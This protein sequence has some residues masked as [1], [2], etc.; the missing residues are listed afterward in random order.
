M[1]S[2]SS[3]IDTDTEPVFKIWVSMTYTSPSLD[4]TYFSFVHRRDM[5]GNGIAQVLRDAKSHADSWRYADIEQI[6]YYAH[7]TRFR[8][9]CVL[10]RP[11]VV[12]TIRGMPDEAITAF[13]NSYR[14]NPNHGP[15][16]AN[17]AVLLENFESW[18]ELRDSPQRQL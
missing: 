18:R 15:T 17:L 14:I 6:V 2:I 9:R 3:S 4:N 5:D 11:G 12:Q 7:R 13:E 16:I 8:E 10:V 1:T